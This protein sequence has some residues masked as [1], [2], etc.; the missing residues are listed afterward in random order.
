MAQ[1][2]QAQHEA[3]TGPR[4]IALR[5]QYPAMTLS[6]IGIQVGITRERVRQMLKRHGLPTKSTISRVFPIFVCRTCGFETTVRHTLTR[7]GVCRECLQRRRVTTLSCAWDGK[8]FQRRTDRIRAR[9]KNPAYTSDRFFCSREH[10]G[11]YIGRHFGFAARPENTGRSYKFKVGDSVIVKVGFMKTRAHSGHH[12]QIAALRR[13]HS[14][15]YSV[16]C[17]CGV[18]RLWQASL[19]CRVSEPAERCCD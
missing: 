9:A 19:L 2:N 12:G 10:Q 17:G 16:L 1:Y 6:Q 3:G 11:Q 18:T 4:V 7:D 14:R 5:R 8:P 13:E 15:A